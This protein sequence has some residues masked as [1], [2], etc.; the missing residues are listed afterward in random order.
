MIFSQIYIFYTSP[1]A[2]TTHTD[3]LTDESVNSAVFLKNYLGGIYIYSINNSITWYR[4]RGIGGFQDLE[5]IRT[6]I[7]PQAPKFQEKK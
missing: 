7:F 2:F 6:A 4:G 1:N 5:L 3:C